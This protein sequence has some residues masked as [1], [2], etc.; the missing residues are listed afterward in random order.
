MLVDG[1]ARVGDVGEV[2]VPHTVALGIEHVERVGEEAV[3][4]GMPDDLVAA[5]V[6]LEQRRVAGRVGRRGDHALHLVPVASVP[7]MHASRAAYGSITARVS[8]SSDSSE[9]SIDDT[10]IPR[11]GITVTNWSRARRCNAS[12]IGVRPIP[13]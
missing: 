11:R 4:G 8:N 2:H 12:R 1:V 3:A 7:R 5:P 13:S 6:D 9:T 10:N